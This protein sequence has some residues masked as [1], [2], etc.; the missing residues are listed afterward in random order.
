MLGFICERFYQYKL[1]DLNTN[2][3]FNLLYNLKRY[4]CIWYK[5][6]N[7][8]YTKKFTLN[9]LKAKNYLNFWAM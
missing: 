4:I 6:S 1:P 5:V 3:I 9:R 8:I 7:K 2:I